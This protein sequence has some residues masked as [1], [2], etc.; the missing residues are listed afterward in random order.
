MRYLQF[1]S[2]LWCSVLHGVN[3]GQNALLGHPPNER[4]F[5]M[6]PQ[7]RKRALRS[8]TNISHCNGLPQLSHG[9]TGF[10]AASCCVEMDRA[11]DNPS[12]TL[13]SPQAYARY[14]L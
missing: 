6:H 2:I 1:M 7:I 11:V 4:G 14:N 9:A 5:E 10:D 3:R 12:T 13:G 8:S